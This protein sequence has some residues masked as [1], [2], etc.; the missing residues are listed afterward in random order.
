MGGKF[1]DPRWL[2][3][4]SY[5]MNSKE[6]ITSIV[7]RRKG[8]SRKGQVP[9]FECQLNQLI[10]FQGN[11]FEHILPVGSVYRTVYLEAGKRI[12]KFYDTAYDLIFFTNA[13]HTHY[14]EYSVTNIKSYTYMRHFIFRD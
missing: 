2:V 1:V 12:G 3:D 4:S 14:D 8:L 11:T 13:V 6:R 7:R 10:K 5:L 9:S